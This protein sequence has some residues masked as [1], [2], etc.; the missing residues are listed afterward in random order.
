MLAAALADPVLMRAIVE[1]RRVTRAQR[2]NA[3]LFLGFL[4]A[5]IGSLFALA[6]SRRMMR[7]ISG[8]EPHLS[9][10]ESTGWHQDELPG[11]PYEIHMASANDVWVETYSPD[12]L[13]HWSSGHWTH[14][15]TAYNPSGGLAAA[16]DRAWVSNGHGIQRFD[17]RVWRPLPVDI[18]DPM[19][20]TANGNDVWAINGHGL[21]AHCAGSACDTHS[22]A[23]QIHDDNWKSGFLGRRSRN[24]GRKFGA[25]SLAWAQD[26]LWFIDKAAWYSSDG[27]HWTEWQGSDNRVWFGGVSGGRLW[28]RTRDSLLAVGDDLVPTSFPL[29]P[30]HFPS[31]VQAG[32]GHVLVASD[33]VLFQYSNGDWNPISF[34]PQL[35]AEVVFNFAVAPDG[36]MWIVAEK[37]PNPI[38]GIGIGVIPFAV[39]IGW[40]YLLKRQAARNLLPSVA[41]SEPRIRF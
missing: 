35:H 34:D 15:G 29:Y 26:R 1:R 8:D 6:H 27:Q 12:G 7:T 9:H 28:F 36:N 24:S 10:R 30:L 17:G 31:Q 3:L 41:T 16:G 2:I 39:I 14:Y 18:P 19:A 37:H 25:R 22:V 23:D 38:G 21:L 20:T 33:Y 32:D 11:I 4:F 5:V 13:S 40:A